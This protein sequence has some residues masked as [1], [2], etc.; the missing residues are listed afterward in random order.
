MANYRPQIMPVSKYYDINPD[1]FEKLGILNIPLNADAPLFIDPMLLESS[2][3]LTFSEDAW[4]AYKAFFQDLLNR[5]QQIPELDDKLQIRAKRTLTELLTAPEQKGLCLGYSASNNKGRGIGSARARQILDSALRIVEN[6]VKNPNL[7][8]VIFLLEEGIGADCISD[9][10]AKIILPQLCEFT[11]TI[12]KQVGIKSK[13]YRVNGKIYDLPQHPIESNCY[14]LF[15]PTDIINKLPTNT[16][17]HSVLWTFMKE[18]QNVNPQ[19]N[20]DLRLNI[21]Q[22]IA[23]I[24]QTSVKDGK[25]DGSIKTALRNIVYGNPDGINSVISAVEH[26]DLPPINIETDLAG[27]NITTK[28][29][30]Y[31]DPSTIDDITKT[32]KLAIIDELLKRFQKF[33]NNR[34][35]Y[36]RELL[37]SKNHPK[38][39]HAW[40]QSLMCYVDSSLRHLNIDITPEFPTGR[41]P[42]DFKFSEGENFKVLVELK[43]ST[44]GQ[45]LN[46]LKKQLEI[47]KNAT[48]N[49][50]KA[51]FIFVDFDGDENKRTSKVQKLFD[52]KREY[53]LDTEILIVDGTLPPSASKVH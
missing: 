53:G 15:V 11:Q 29:C 18:F 46:G 14:L 5:M 49:V 30:K 10:T 52:V 1:V 38:N 8:S 43:L 33:V 40:Q 48:T 42:I 7:F 28:F 24:W 41:G 23:D 35:D 16:D 25:S 27:F 13:R 9:L 3:Y 44:N 45:Y 17:L 26:T 50:K 12:A 22:Q 20:S 19:N 6:G 34:T 4:G 21:N 36:K 2:T 32:D 47:Y 39:E 31:F 51:Y 37:Y